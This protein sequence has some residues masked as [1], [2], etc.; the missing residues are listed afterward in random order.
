MVLYRQHGSNVIGAQTR[1]GSLVKLSR[2]PIALAKSVLAAMRE[3]V[4]EISAL[5]QRL[6]ERAA[7][8]TSRRDR[9][10]SYR[11]AFATS[12][13]ITARLHS[14][15]A[16]G[17]RPTRSLSRSVFPMVVA[18]YPLYSGKARK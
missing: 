16:S 6:T 14:L 18:A 1:R 11:D 4:R 17:A 2:S 12:A 9:V 15:H 5:D 8:A 13:P 7:G 10:R 3:S